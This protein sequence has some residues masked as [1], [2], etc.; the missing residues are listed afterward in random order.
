MPVNIALTIGGTNYQTIGGTNYQSKIV[1]IP[2]EQLAALIRQHEDHF[3]TQKKLIERL[4][5]DLDLN[6]SQM[7]EALRIL[8]E[9]D[10]PV[11]H[12][13]AK[14]VQIAGHFQN[15]KEWSIGRSRRQPGHHCSEIR[16]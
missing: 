12:L 2:P 3:Q 4:E 6:E 16:C 8:G 14:L 5:R 11:L 10:V 15:L 13:G 1:C 7:R 9:N